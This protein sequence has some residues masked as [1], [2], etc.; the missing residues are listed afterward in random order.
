MFYKPWVR[1]LVCLLMVCVLLINCS[2]VKAKASMTGTIAIGAGIAIASVLI[3]LGVC[4]ATDPSGFD[5]VVSSCQD[6][7]AGAGYVVDGMMD[8]IALSPSQASFTYGLSYGV[9]DAIRGWLFDFGILVDQSVTLPD[10]LPTGFDAAYAE[11]ATYPYAALVCYGSNALDGW[12]NQIR[13]VYCNYSLYVGGSGTSVKLYNSSS[14]TMTAWGSGSNKWGSASN[15]SIN[16]YDADVQFFGTGVPSI[17]TDIAINLAKVAAPAYAIAKGYAEWATNAVAVPGADVGEADQEEVV[18]YPVGLGQTYEET[19]DKAQTDVW[20]GSSTYEQTETD[21]DT[22]TG[23]FA[24][25]AVGTFIKS[26]VSSFASWFTDIIAKIQSIWEVI[27]AGFADVVAGLRDIASSIIS[28]PQTIADLILAGIRA[29][30]VPEADYLTAKWEAVRA[31]FGF[32]DSI[33]ETFEMFSTSLFAFQ[34]EP[35]VIYVDLSSNTGP[36]DLGGK[37]AILDLRW[38]AEY[39]GVTDAL[40]SAFMLLVFVWRVGIHLPGTLRGASGEVPG[41]IVPSSE[42]KG[43][44]IQR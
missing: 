10:T 15:G 17:V 12:A 44:R 27:T 19:R 42:E 34:T 43:L 25:T 21:T 24:D 39:K 28:L 32:A 31:E 7:L 6:F 29:I 41:T 14:A 8:V 4:A 2:P 11:A 36:Y 37:A 20:A 22:I 5:G 13:I 9:I 26:L 3:G 38:F 18:V 23:T 35:P 1:C 16:V 30:F 40:I 33:I